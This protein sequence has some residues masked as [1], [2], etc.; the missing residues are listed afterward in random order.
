MNNTKTLNTAYL[1]ILV[2]FFCFAFLFCNIYMVI[3]EVFKSV[4]I[5][6]HVF[7]PEFCYLNEHFID[8]KHCLFV[9]F[10]FVFLFCFFLF[11]NIYMVI[12]EIFNSS[13]LHFWLIMKHFLK[14]CVQIS[15]LY[16]HNLCK[17]FL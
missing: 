8:F 1:F 5:H 3:T 9:C 4:Y 7:R 10:G 12:A 15:F 14:S 16:L 2:V 13:I 17:V 6:T 11:C